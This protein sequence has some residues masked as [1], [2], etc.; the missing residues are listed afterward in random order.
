[1]VL[2]RNGRVVSTSIVKGSGDAAFDE[3]AIAMSVGRIRWRNCRR[4]LPTRI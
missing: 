2:D 3:A 4:W 1:L